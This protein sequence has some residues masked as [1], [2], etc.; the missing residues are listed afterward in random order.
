MTD[1]VLRKGG[2]NHQTQTNLFQQKLFYDNENCN[3]DRFG[4]DHFSHAV[5]HKHSGN[6]KEESLPNIA[7][8]CRCCANGYSYGP[9]AQLC[10][11]GYHAVC[12]ARK[13]VGDES[14]QC[15]RDYFRDRQGYY[16]PCS[17]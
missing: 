3:D 7:D 16:I 11:G 13:G 6:K 1:K 17:N 8:G 5:W 15:G 9:G 10:L 12:V 14:E 4:L 2:I